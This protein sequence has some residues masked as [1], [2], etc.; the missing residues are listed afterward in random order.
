[1]RRRDDDH[2]TGGDVAQR[3][4]WLPWLT[5]VLTDK[6]YDLDR[7]GGRKQLAD[8]TGLA[9]GMIS[10][11]LAGE[12]MSYET[13]LTF[14][15]GTGIPISD[16]LVRSGKASADDFS[17]PGS[18]TGQAAVLSRKRLTPEEVAK[19]AG[20][21][22]EDRAWFATMVRRMRKQSTTGDGGSSAGGAAAEG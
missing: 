16:L 17:Q 6:G 7:R 8:D 5:G 10:R 9:G 13:L 1:M 15:R 3:P 14:S 18:K 2:E 12:S 20:V 22:E 11:L 21:P 19:A 4:D